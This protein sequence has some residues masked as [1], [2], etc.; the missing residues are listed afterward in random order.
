[1][2]NWFK[3]RKSKNHKYIQNENAIENSDE[4]KVREPV[5]VAERILALFAVIGKVH[6]GNSIEF[7][8]WF[9]NN[10]IEKYLSNEEATFIKTNEPQEN[11]IINFSW[12]AEALISLLW[13]IKLIKDMPALNQQYDVYS[14]KNINEIINNPDDFKS[15][16]ELRPD[17]ELKSMEFELYHQ[18]WRVRDAQLFEKKM[19][20]ELNPSIVYERRY[21]L[22]WL[23]GD[24]DDWDDV[25]TDT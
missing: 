12:R 8:D 7:Q 6:Q 2:F 1:M 16:I 25:P 15:K 4:L 13:S 5:K 24:G 3:K 10:S 14:V 20:S 11:E 21:A 17:K 22:S 23:I 9:T 19:P 18:H